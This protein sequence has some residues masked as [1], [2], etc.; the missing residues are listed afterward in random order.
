MIGSSIPVFSNERYVC[1]DCGKELGDNYSH[2]Q[3][4]KQPTVNKLNG[5]I[6]CN[7]CIDKHYED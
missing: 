7:K 5:K 4:K 2:K 3:N 6:Y 1:K